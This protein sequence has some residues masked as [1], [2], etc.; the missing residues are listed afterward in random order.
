MQL[1]KGLFFTNFYLF[2]M[3]FALLS[4]FRSTAL[5]RNSLSL[6]ALRGGALFATDT[7]KARDSLA[8]VDEDG[9][10]KRR[11]AAWRNWISSEKDAVF[12]PAKDRYHL[13]VSYAC[14]W[15]HRTLIVRGLKG[16]QDVIPVTVVHPVWQYTKEGIESDMHR[17]WIFGDPGGKRLK[18]TQGFGSFPAAYSGN[19]PNPLYD[20]VKTI[21]G[22]YERA[23]DIEGKYSVPILWDTET[24]TI[25][26]NESSEI[27]RMF[28]TEFNEYAKNPELDLYPEELR[29]AIDEVN[30]WVYDGIN[31]G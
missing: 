3:G 10:F 26:S 16:L 7:K 15:A 12:P 5:H 8:E 29:E 21:R 31:N 28:N 2:N 22:M 23:G 4:S 19:E 6:S 13:F 17:G 18:N 20:D 27:I 1:I 14:P 30:E 24:E 11:D 9:A 25:V